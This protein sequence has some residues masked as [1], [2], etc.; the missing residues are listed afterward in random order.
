MTKSKQD[1]DKIDCMSA[2]NIEN[3]TELSWP[4]KQGVIYDENNTG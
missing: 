1:N 2:V 3:E 4:I